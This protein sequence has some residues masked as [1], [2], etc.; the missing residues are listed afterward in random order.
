MLIKVKVHTE[1]KE[2]KVV[3]NREDEFEVWV[4][5][6]AEQGRANEAL[7][8]L[9]SEYFNKGVRIVKGSRRRNKIMRVFD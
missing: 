9:L 7:L 2:N 4:R 8:S 6:S 3:Q 5:E 1:A